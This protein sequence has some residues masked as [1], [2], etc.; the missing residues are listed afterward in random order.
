M[1]T[2]AA[3]SFG[4]DA[5]LDFVGEMKD[6]AELPNIIGEIERRSSRLDADAASAALAACDLLAARIGRPAAD[7]PDSA[8]L[9][10]A[11]VAE[12]VLDTARS[13]VA[14]V[15]DAS[16]LA[17]LWAEE[18]DAEWQA[19]LADLLLRLT[20]SIPY[21]APETPAAP[22]PPEIPDDFL[23]YCYVC[24][25]MVTKR[26][27]IYFEEVTEGLG[28]VACHPHRKCIED[29]IPGPHWNADG[30]PT[31]GTRRKLLQDMGFEIE[32]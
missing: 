20:P 25:G 15:R 7:V 5:A 26:N 11:E 29:Q 31:E 30:S 28:T 18:D 24:Y 19:A 17:E 21:S 8:G 6:L 32:P 27:G 13:L 23:G 1:G 3:G 9:A 4:N 14:R 2:W 12:A 22:A 10:Q 16:E